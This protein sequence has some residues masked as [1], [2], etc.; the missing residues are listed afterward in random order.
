[1]VLF[2][3]KS[4]TMICSRRCH[5]TRS[6]QQHCGS[7]RGPEIAP[8]CEIHIIRFQPGPSQVPAKS[9]PVENQRHLD[10]SVFFWIQPQNSGFSHQIWDSAIN[11]WIFFLK[12]GFL[13]F[14]LDFRLFVFC[15]LVSAD[16]KSSNLQS[17]H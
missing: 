5:V 10:F 1:M 14:W 13:F 12:S 16:A 15:F 3:R 9:Q 4:V 17:E 8:A 11:F 2:P 7:C 6:C